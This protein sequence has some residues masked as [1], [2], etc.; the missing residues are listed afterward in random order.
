MRDLIILFIHLSVTV[1]RLFG[2][3][4]ARSVVAE[5][6]LVKHQLVILNR[7]RTRAPT[8]RPSDRILVGLCAILIRPSRLLRSAIA[9]KPS[10]ILTFHRALVSRKYHLLFTPKNRRKP[11]PAGPSPELIAVI[12]E[13]KRRNPRFGY[14]RIADQI[15]LAFDIDVHKDVVR[16]VLVRHY[17]P[18][19]GS[20]GPSWLTFLGHSKD[21]LWSVDLFRCESM[22]LQSHWV[23]VVM[24]QFTRR[25][26]GFS[27]HAGPVD[28]P[29]VC[30]LFNHILGASVAPQYLSSDND[31]LFK[32][33]R[34]KANLRIL[35]VAE[36]KTVPYVPLSHP[37]VERLIG[38]IR[39]EFLDHVPFWG[40]FDLERKLSSFKDYYNCDRAHRGVAT[41]VP[42][43]QPA[44]AVRKTPC[45]DNY[46]W[47][48]CCRGLYQLPVAA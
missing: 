23:M 7:S 9:L 13:M 35:D 36:V 28:G 41:A 19:S 10:T 4:G 30:R 32:F 11:G 27:V 37:F 46:R 45:L 31:P 21:S 42:D 6:L 38:T 26:I 34:W 44:D 18:G 2:P 22:I 33:H 29:A 15:S 5:S 43:L 25:I 48:S 16:R 12:V 20:S 40:A 17:R 14:Q 8:L 3:G 24:D 1:A 47:K 39:R